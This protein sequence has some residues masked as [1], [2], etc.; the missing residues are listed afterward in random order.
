MSAK[1]KIN[2]TDLR[3][4]VDQG[5]STAQIAA[6]FG[7]QSPAVTRACRRHGIALSK[8]TGIRTGRYPPEPTRADD[9]RDLDIIRRLR[10]GEGFIA[11]SQR[12]GISNVTVQRIVKNIEA[13]DL[14]ESGEPVMVVARA[15]AWPRR[16]R[17]MP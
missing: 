9:D 12:Y 8:G 3:R 5:L 7:V 16:K 4:L 6:R 14:K 15:Y 17:K 2:P 11:V 1:A 10:A 13:A